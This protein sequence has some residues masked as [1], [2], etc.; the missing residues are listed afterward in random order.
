VTLYGKFHNG[1]ISTD[2]ML[3]KYV[4]GKVRIYIFRNTR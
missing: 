2:F 3:Q 1:L 4:E